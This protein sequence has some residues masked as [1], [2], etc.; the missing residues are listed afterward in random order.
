MAFLLCTPRTLGAEMA[1]MMWIQ[2]R[3]E[4]GV[5]AALK[6]IPLALALAA[7]AKAI[8]DRRLQQRQVDAAEPC[9]SR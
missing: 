6:G 2:G 1:I 3:A 8:V 4:L 7:A 5:T 9:I